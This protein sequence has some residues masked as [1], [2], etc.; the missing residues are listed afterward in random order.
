MSQVFDLIEKS[1]SNEQ[2]ETAR[3]SLARVTAASSVK[4]GKFKNE[5]VNSRIDRGDGGVVWLT[6]VTDDQYNA[7][8]R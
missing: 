8:G 2:A 6:R 4:K 5:Q 7:A 3:R 1:I